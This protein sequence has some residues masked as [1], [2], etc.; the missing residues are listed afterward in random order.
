MPLWARDVWARSTASDLESI[1]STFSSWD[2]CMAKSYCKWPV[3]VAIIIASVIVIAILGCI[4]NCL[5]CG[6]QCCKCC[7]SCCCPSGR[8]R[9][10]AP[11][12]PKHY[13]DPIYTQPPPAPNPIYQPPQAPPVYRGANTTATFDSPS[14]SAATSTIH[15]DALPEMPT[16]A[17]AVDKHVEDHSHEDLEMEPLNPPDRKQGAGTPINPGA[18][19]ADYPPDRGTPPLA[20]YRGFNSTDPYARRSPGPAAALAATQDPHGHRS[21]GASLA[22]NTQIDPYGRRSPAVASPAAAAA[23][24]PYNRRSPG[25]NGAMD[26]Y[27]RRSPAQGPYGRRSPGPNAVMDP[28]GHSSPGALNNTS[29]NDPYNHL[30]SPIGAPVSS[31]YEH[32]PYDQP[33]DDYNNGYHVVSSPPPVTAYRSQTNYSSIYGSESQ[34]LPPSIP[35]SPP[36]PFQSQAPSVYTAYGSHAQDQSHEYGVAVSDA[37]RDRPPSLLMSGRKPVPNTYRNV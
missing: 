14:K 9:F 26:P 2:K 35:N 22:Y 19:Y 1:P 37:N 28:Y 12:Q 34:V 24:D 16:W 30:T 27:T 23:V 10:K 18:A 4:I 6:Y 11:K 15:E 20:G 31:P 29:P 17:A 32:Q 13:D 25:P 36:P 3:I 33:Y 8:R 7:C 5:C 21:P